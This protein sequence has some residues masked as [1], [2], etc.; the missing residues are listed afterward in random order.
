MNLRLETRS[1]PDLTYDS[2]TL[3]MTP[4]IDESYWKYRVRLS[5]KQAIVGFP[6]FGVIGIGFAVE[7]DWNTNLPSSSRAEEIY[8]HIKHNQGDEGISR[9]HCLAAIRMIQE[10]AAEGQ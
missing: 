4:P 3:S 2:G 1:Q 7:D 6:K 9:E 8:E 5:E 10:A